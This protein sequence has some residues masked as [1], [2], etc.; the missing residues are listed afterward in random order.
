[1]AKITA[2]LNSKNVSYFHT[3]PCYNNP[4]LNNGACSEEDGAAVCDCI[5]GYSGETCAQSE[6]L[7]VIR[8]ALAWVEFSN[9]FDK[10]P[11]IIGRALALVEFSNVIDRKLHCLVTVINLYN[12][13]VKQ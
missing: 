13:S 2:L 11:K 9:I 5:P 7:K 6:L 3:D 1:M 10:F 12:A 4:C 8:R